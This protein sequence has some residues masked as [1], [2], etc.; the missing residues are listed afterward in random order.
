MKVAV[1]YSGFLR[2]IQKTFP[3]AKST[4]VIPNYIEMPKKHNLDIKLSFVFVGRIN[5]IKNIHLLI[6][7]LAIIHKE[8]P[9]IELD[10]VGSAR[11]P[12]ELVYQKSLEALTQT[13]N[14]ASSVNF[15]G[16]LNGE[17]KNKVIASNMALVLPSKSE[18]FGN[19]ILEAFAQ[20]TPVIASKNTPWN[21]LEEHN[22]GYWVEA[23]ANKLAEA[24]NSILNL[25]SK[26]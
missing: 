12:Y 1:C 19:V 14:I 13:L 6:N 18:N 17:E 21:I 9:E 7:A 25:E 10:I 23:N 22:A 5:P 8:H 24:M 4:V 20:G 16:H 15:L 3:K 26:K 11:L 2:N